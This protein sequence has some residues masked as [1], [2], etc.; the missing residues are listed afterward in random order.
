M[1][2][3]FPEETIRFFLDLRFHND[4]AFF[5]AH[6]QEYEEYVKRPF[7]AFIEALAPTVLGI[8]GD[9]D[10]RPGKCLARI[11]RDTRFTKDKSPYRDHMWLLLRRSG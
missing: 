2:E 9:M 6:Q 8:A 4:H 3:G 1:F 7:A 10:T 5:Q 11:H